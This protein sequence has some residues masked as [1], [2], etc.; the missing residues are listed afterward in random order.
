MSTERT[1]RNH[2][3]D[4]TGQ[5]GP[6]GSTG[7][8]APAG[9]RR[10]A[11]SRTGRN[12]R[13]AAGLAGVGVVALVAA[14]VA[15]G[16]IAAPAA[17]EVD[18]A[19]APASLSAAPAQGV[20]P[21]PPRLPAGAAE[22]TD[23]EFSPVSTSA[24]SSMTSLLLSDLAGRFP[25]STLRPLHQAASDDVA[26]GTV[27]KLTTPQPAEVQQGEPATSGPD[28][29]PVREAT[30][31]NI[32]NPGGPDGAASVVTVEPIGGQ[33]GRAQ[34]LARY[35]AADGDLTGLDTSACM[36]PA[37]EHWLAGATTTVGS[38]AI[39]VL[40]NPSASA[41]TVD[42]T[43]HG[44][45]GPVEAPGTNGIL[46]APGQTRSIVLGGVAPDE[47]H[48][49]VHVEAQGGAVGAAIQ[50]HRLYGITPGGV[51][52][53]QPT[54]APSRGAVMPGVKVP[55]AESTKDITAQDGYESAGPAVMI[56]APTVGT[57]A[58]VT[59][60][61]MN[62]PADLPGKSTVELAAGATVRYPLTGLASGTYT[63]TVTAEDPVV[64]SAAGLRGEPGRP[65]DIS[66]VSAVGALGLE[67]LVAR[68]S[69]TTGLLVMYSV[70]GGSVEFT[71]VFD[72]GSTGTGTVQEVA[73]GTSRAVDLD[74]LPGAGGGRVIGVLLTTGAGDV[75][76]GVATGTDEGISAYPV[77]PQAETAAGVPVRVGY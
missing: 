45:E 6:T 27:R 60:S 35:S 53:I 23:T 28:G 51:E 46:L 71:P 59:V 33:P 65:L 21:G 69:E 17:P 68:P 2:P 54:A 39:L 73:A 55:S 16:T 43:L 74:R 37:H 67:R 36:A 66:S 13:R 25:G 8:P 1:E 75:H 20:C 47:D 50:Q 22:G 44:A 30:V 32:A 62:G 3:T 76:A 61:G 15:V 31:R 7:G 49:T 34:A 10:T 41:S 38:T 12:A 77:V 40:S 72:D 26:A 4:P 64:A 57:T 63:V 29:V 11:R 42:L 58:T 19:A 9:R 14:A 56:A 18:G 52:I 5:A 70:G 48:L 24:R